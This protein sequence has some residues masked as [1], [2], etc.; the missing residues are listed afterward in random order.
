M[1]LIK[2]QKII[3][4]TWTY[5][6]D[7]EP[8]QP[9]NI[10]VSASRWQAEKARLLSHDGKV[11]IRINSTLNLEAIAEDLKQYQL[12]ELNFATFADGRSFSQAQLLRQRYQYKGEIR[13]VG[14]FMLDQIYYLSRTGVN[15]F[16]LADAE[17]L[18]TALATLQ[19]FSINYQNR[20][21]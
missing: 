16:K 3:E 4:D 12:I 21:N 2:D 13:A 15:A 6:D 17:Q 11:G 1:Q 8:L 19:D 7:N 14:N 5:V 9:G 10:T 18:P 20:V